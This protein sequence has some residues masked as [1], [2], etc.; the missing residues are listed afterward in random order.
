MKTRCLYLIAL[1]MGVCFSLSAQE[2]ATTYLK[3]DSARIQ[4]VGN[5]LNVDFAV[6][7]GRLELS[8][9]QQ[10][11]VT[12][13]IAGRT[14]TMELQPIVF[15]GKIRNKSNNQ[16]I[17]LYKKNIQPYQTVL[18]K[19]QNR[20]IPAGVA[21]VLVYKTDVPYENWMNGATVL[22]RREISGCRNQQVADLSPIVLGK[23]GNPVP[24]RITYIIPVREGRR[25]Q[26]RMTAHVNFPQGRSVVLMDF[27]DNSRQIA[28]IDSLT[29]ALS[30]DRNVR[31]DTMRLSGYASP[32][33]RYDYNTRLAANRAAAVKNYLVQHYGV[34]ASAFVTEG[35]SEDWNGL[36]QWVSKSDLKNKKQVLNVIDSVKSADARDAS[37]RRIDNS[38]TYNT[39]MS[40]AYPPLRRVDYV[41]AYGEPEFSMED[42]KAA[43]RNNPED[44]NLYEMYLV[45]DSYPD[46]S[47]EMEEV[48]VIA[49]RCYPHESCPHN[50]LAAI[51]LQRGDTATARQHLQE[52]QNDPQVM[53][54]M[55]V[56]YVME[57]DLDQARQC[58]TQAKN[59]G[60]QDA[61]YN[62]AHLQ[63][64]AVK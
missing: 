40:Q 63:E 25:P 11:T 64:L 7:F 45:A 32:E 23:L 29:R 31:I 62:L 49:A 38:R 20:R 53:N 48:Y 60:N 46:G 47:P 52:V 5:N 21:P 9:T 26:Q 56:L 41:I 15:A 6:D 57:G 36:R 43:L 55:G 8:N 37:L 24:P 28:R 34:P 59:A 17:A 16:D 30:K 12:P 4:R 58:F 50:N 51:A 44:L 22:L 35:K 3:V 14:D 19:K 54:N 10:M 61:A 27:G 1:A 2:A 33:G 39:L 18:V 42:A 13:V